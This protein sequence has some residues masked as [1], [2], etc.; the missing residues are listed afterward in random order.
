[1][2]IVLPQTTRHTAHKLMRWDARYRAT[3]R[4][5]H[6]RLL[7]DKTTDA[8]EDSLSP[9]HTST[10]WPL[11][12]RAALYTRY[13]KLSNIKNMASDPRTSTVQLQRPSWSTPISV[14][15]TPGYKFIILN[16]ASDS[17][18]SM[19]SYNIYRYNLLVQDSGSSGPARVRDRTARCRAMHGG[20]TM[21]IDVTS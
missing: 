12:S 3:H 16:T 9:H 19:T 18:R 10:M 14:A 11:L 5:T 1:M 2:V 8:A 7:S 4:I 20:M 15:S 13:N 21:T 17:D 6:V